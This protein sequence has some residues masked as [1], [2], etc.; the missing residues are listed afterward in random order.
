M[1]L[2]CC[3]PYWL[4][5]NG[6]LNLY[7]ALEQDV[8]CDVLVIGG[9]ISGAL[10]AAALVEKGLGV[11]VID[12]RE[13][14]TGS[15]CA[16]TGLLLYDIDVELYRLRKQ[17]GAD[18][19]DEAYRQ[20]YA[21]FDDLPGW[22]EKAGGADLCGY[23]DKGSLYMASR[24]RD[25]ASLE[26]EHQARTETGLQCRLLNADAVREEFGIEAYGGLH[27]S[28]A[29]ECDSYA[30]THG[31]LRYAAQQGAR[32]YDRTLVDKLTETADG[33]TAVTQAGC[34]ITA[35]HVVLA[36]G[37]ES[38]AW[39]KK[40]VASNHSTYVTIS[41][42]VENLPEWLR[43]T[44]VWE[45]ARPYIYV[46]STPDNRV[47]VGGADVAFKNAAARDKL[48]PRQIRR[49]EDRAR[50][51]LQGVNFKTAFSWAG[52]FAETSD[53]LPRIGLT[54]EWQHVHF[55]LGYGGNGITFS[56]IAADIIAGA[57]TGNP[58][59]Y[60]YAFDFEK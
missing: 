10:A 7:P 13:I 6:L 23:R 8:S 53:G 49:L 38:Q 55:A 46:R 26:K 25:V 22:I 16:S 12:G 41:D 28:R 47:I 36:A 29:A 2:Y 48:L 30:F 56:M 39:L 45:T 58:R 27:T 34:V 32:V 21:V 3:N 60:A 1:D 59:P 51:L 9:G 18:V 20:S 14:A 4:L 5:K 40:S 50:E 54:R 33:A 37:Y 15:S 31:L 11:V 44:H 42:P 57:I 17:R 35:K 24:K 19:A 52:T 43:E